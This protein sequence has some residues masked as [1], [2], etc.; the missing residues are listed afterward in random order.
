MWI[1]KLLVKFMKDYKKTTWINFQVLNYL[2]FKNTLTLRTLYDI[3]KTESEVNKL[4]ICLIILKRIVIR[5]EI[6]FGHI[7][8]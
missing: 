2:F 6:D 5:F 3:I 4:K 1:K 8:R 7:S